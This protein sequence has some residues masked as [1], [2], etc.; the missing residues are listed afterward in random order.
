M[1]IGKNYC[2]WAMTAH[3]IWQKQ[4]LSWYKACTELQRRLRTSLESVHL[5][6]DMLV[7]AI[8]FE[9]SLRQ[10]NFVHATLFYAALP[11]QG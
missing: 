10:Y 9:F 3:Y 11:G 8:Q 1:S 5:L 4:A 7:R 6:C 2:G